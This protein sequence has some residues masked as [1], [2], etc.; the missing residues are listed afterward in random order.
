VYFLSADLPNDAIERL[1]RVARAGEE[2]VGHGR[3]LYVHYP[4]GIA[5]SKLSGVLIE[6]AGVVATG[7][8]WRTVMRLHELTAP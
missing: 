7:R 1:T 6:R 5:R 2:A 8:N 3:E 4:A